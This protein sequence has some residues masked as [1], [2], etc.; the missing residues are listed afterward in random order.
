MSRPFSAFSH[1]IVMFMSETHVLV[2]NQRIHFD[3]FLNTDSYISVKLTK[4]VGFSGVKIIF[5]ETKFF[6]C[7]KNQNLKLTS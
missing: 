3:L 1:I 2:P 7:F 6:F 4:I 5:F